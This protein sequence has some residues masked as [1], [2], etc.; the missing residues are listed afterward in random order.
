V[1]T[2]T[3]KQ[4]DDELRAELWDLYDQWFASIPGDDTSFFE[5]YLADD[6][7]YTNYY[8]E[9]RGKPEYLE[10]I[11]PIGADAPRNRLMELIVRPYEPLVLVHGLYVV[12]PEYAP[13]A[14]TDTRFTAV[15]TRQDGE[16]RA[17][18]HHATTVVHHS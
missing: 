3:E 2:M 18:A 6:W 11:A 4:A 17:L 8:G 14:G 7:Y 15:W 1:G 12:A 10:L 9:V 5:R 13:A 16:L